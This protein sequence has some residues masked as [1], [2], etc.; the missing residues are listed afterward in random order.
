MGHTLTNVLV[1]V[2]FAT[3]NR[4]KT[5]TA[6]IRERLHAYLAQVANNQGARTYLVNGGLEHVHLLLRPRE[7]AFVG[8]RPRPQIQ[9]VRVAASRAVAQLLLAT[10]LFRL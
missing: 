3:K 8:P 9:L 2:V 1:H 7:A 10:R 4:E 5:L 6:A